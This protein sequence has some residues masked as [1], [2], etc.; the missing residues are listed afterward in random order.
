[1]TP[2]T[3]GNYKIQRARW[4]TVPTQYYNHIQEL[5][6]R[7]VETKSLTSTFYQDTRQ[8]GK[9]THLDFW[10]ISTGI[11]SFSE[12]FTL[13]KRGCRRIVVEPVV[14]QDNYFRI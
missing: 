9:K 3:G 11:I 1:M 14:K 12:C 8:K 7:Y 5:M 13:F 6:I 10:F 2:E 4:D